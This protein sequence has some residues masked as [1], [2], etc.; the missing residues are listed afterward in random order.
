MQQR[1]ITGTPGARAWLKAA[2]QA[3]GNHSDRLNAINVFPVPDGDTGSNLYQ[4][5]KTAS[6]VASRSDADDWGAVLA[7]A[8]NAALDDA[9]GNSGTLFAVF[10]TGFAE[11]LAGRERL[12]AALLYEALERGQLRS[13][14]ALTDPVE[15]TMLSAMSSASAALRAAAGPE[16]DESNASLVRT[17]DLAIEGVRGAVLR[18]EAELGALARA[19]VVDAGAVG[20]L[21][22]MESLRA[23]ITQRPFD[24]TALE[25][26]HG[27]RIQDRHVHADFD[28]DD[29]IEFMCSVAL[30][31]LEAASLRAELDGLGESVIMS[32]L[33]LPGDANHRWR[34]HVHVA[35][36]EAA[37]A[38]VERYGAPENVSVTELSGDSAARRD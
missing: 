18:S 22:I 1:Y 35:D 32:A 33:N 10:L 3:V 29:G 5:I 6:S 31:P 16:R 34:I 13:W 21:L 8:A 37:L 20:F 14:S 36:A 17:L 38:V 24:D 19:H 12:T 30:T 25:E 2:E 4:T 27:Y 28:G 9:R 26:L 7:A 23:A 15:G 11:P